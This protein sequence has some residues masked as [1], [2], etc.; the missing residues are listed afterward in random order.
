MALGV[1]LGK[2]G[3]YVLNEAGPAPLAADTRRTLV[4]AQRALIAMVLLA[5]PCLLAV[6]GGAA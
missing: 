5:V 3:V 6:H 4:L 1:R 2:P